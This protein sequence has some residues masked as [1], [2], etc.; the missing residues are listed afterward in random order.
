MSVIYF[1]LFAFLM[2]LSVTIEMICTKPSWWEKSF[3]YKLAKG[4]KDSFFGPVSEKTGW[5]SNINNT[6]RSSKTIM[7]AGMVIIGLSHWYAFHYVLLLVVAIAVLYGAYR[8][9]LTNIFNNEQ[10]TYFKIGAGVVMIALSVIF[11]WQFNKLVQSPETESVVE[12]L[13]EEVKTK[14]AII[15]AERNKNAAIMD[16][17][18]A[19]IL[20]NETAV[21]VIDT[22]SFRNILRDFAYSA[23]PDTSMWVYPL[24]TTE[25]NE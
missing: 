15:E 18:E 9:G 3:L 2:A 11:G 20:R 13:L 4:N 14:D 25:N 1:I 17:I 6:A 8:Y 12:E 5:F 24:K 10:H 21:N 22:T 23:A 19:R 7:A 16:S